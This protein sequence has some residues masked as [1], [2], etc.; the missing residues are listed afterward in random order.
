MKNAQ[1]VFPE[2]GVWRAE[3]AWMAKPERSPE[4]K[5]IWLAGPNPRPDGGNPPSLTSKESESPYQS[6]MT[7]DPEG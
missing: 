1:G 2:E 5:R 6:R 3:R 7:K 4:P